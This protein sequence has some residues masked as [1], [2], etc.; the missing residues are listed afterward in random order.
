MALTLD[1]LINRSSLNNLKCLTNTD[2]LSVKIDSVNILDNPDVLKW[3]K[4][5]ELV[6]TTGYI[7]KDSEDLQFNILREL[8]NIGC[9]GLGIKIKRFFDTIP[10]N[11]I[12]AANDIGLPIIEIPFYYSFSDISKIIYNE[13]Y[14]KNLTSI[15][16][17]YTIINK[18]SNCYFNNLG[19]DHMLKEISEIIHKSIVLTNSN[20]E[21][22]SLRLIPEDNQIINFSDND[23]FELSNFSF[24]ISIN[25]NDGIMEV[26]KKFSIN[27]V[28]FD[29][30]ALT[31]SSMAGSLCILLNQQDLSSENKSVLKK[32]INI[33]SL[34][35]EKD[36]DFKA[37]TSLYN[38]LFFEYLISNEAKSD[39][40]IIKLCNYYGFDYSK[41]RICI[42]FTVNNTEDEFTSKQI[43]K[44]IH[45]SALQ[46]L[47]T[48][49]NSFVCTNNDIMTIFI[50]FSTDKNNIEIMN[51]TIDNLKILCEQLN[52][53]LTC[54]YTVSIS[55]CH[56]GIK[57]ITT[58]FNDCIETSRLSFLFTE[59][60][61]ILLYNDLIHYHVL[62]KLP[63]AELRKLCDDNISLL[64]KY[65]EAKETNLVEVLKTYYRCK[66]NCSETSD[67]LFIHRNTF[68]GRL[69]KI[70]HILNIDF[71][72]YNKVFSLY[73][74]ICAYELLNSKYE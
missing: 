21:I 71:N 72:D 70:K 60:K 67:A 68:S 65:D 43:F 51:K 53:K 28:E 59:N 31:L 45:K 24:P 39:G 73:L 63:R 8:K 40:E 9:S 20:N 66:F 44:I 46:T 49:H 11:I 42:N 25:S 4:K 29:V 35:L 15:E 1:W 38:N 6:I 54:K 30:Y 16:N 48:S 62:K 3:I 26:Y 55:R 41:K 12:N 2:I 5:D 13:L 37:H 23:E 17:E 69:E 56:E 18:I 64:T 27:N 10:E 36:K 33:I 14:N 74:S 57:T 61:N 47:C 50:F 22:I 52:D 58:A 34:E 7:F 32:L 19:I